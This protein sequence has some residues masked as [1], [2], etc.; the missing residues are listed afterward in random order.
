VH[1]RLIAARRSRLALIERR[2]I[3]RRKSFMQGRVFF[4]RRQSSMD[5]LIRNFTKVGAH[6][7]FSGTAALPDAFEIHVPEGNRSGAMAR[8][9]N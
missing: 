2:A 6:L 8:A 1:H 9:V 5:C 7:H 4:N 3:A